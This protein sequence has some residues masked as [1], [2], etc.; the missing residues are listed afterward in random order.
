MSGQIDGDL[1][2]AV[3]IVTAI[4][5]ALYAAWYREISEAIGI[6]VRRYRDDRNP[7]IEKVKSVRLTR[8]IPLLVASLTFFLMLLPIAASVVWEA[9]Q[10]LLEGVTEA[11]LAYDLT[12]TAFVAVFFASG[13]LSFLAI[14]ATVSLNRT[15]ARLRKSDSPG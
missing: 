10:K 2:S 1:L 3:S 6:T 14:G 4:I 12:K 11:A 8:A 7:E 13:W 5:T 9:V 15:M